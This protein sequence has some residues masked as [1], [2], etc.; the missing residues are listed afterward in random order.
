MKFGAQFSMKRLLTSLLSPV[1][2]GVIFSSSLM[3]M[4]ANANDADEPKITIYHT[5]NKTFYEY[6]RNGQ[7]LEI[8]VVPKKGLPYYLVPADN[9]DGGFREQAESSLSVPKW[10][11]FSW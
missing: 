10:V 7:L 3:A 6:T 9:G 1:L 2:A 8:K 5:E 4:N 11:I